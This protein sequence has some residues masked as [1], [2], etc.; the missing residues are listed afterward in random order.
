MNERRQTI[1]RLVI[2]CISESVALII[3]N[4]S[5]VFTKLNP[6]RG[7]WNRHTDTQR[8]TEFDD[9]FCKKFKLFLLNVENRQRKLSVKRKI[10][11]TKCPR[12]LNPGKAIAMAICPIIVHFIAKCMFNAR[13]GV[14]IC[15][16]SKDAQKW[17]VWTSLTRMVFQVEHHTYRNPL[18][19][20]G[21]Y[22]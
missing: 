4:V 2:F 16:C 21:Y 5:N 12:S 6:P 19:A 15:M 8:A 1:L 11:V 14:W 7:I 20:H 9:A 17:L 10:G 18:I 22:G 13:C 3:P